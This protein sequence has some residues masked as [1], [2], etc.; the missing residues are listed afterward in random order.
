MEIQDQGYLENTSEKLA[1]VRAYE[2]MYVYVY[3]CARVK[4]FVV[5]LYWNGGDSKPQDVLV[6]RSRARLRPHFLSFYLFLERI[7]YGSTL[8]WE[9]VYT[10]S[11]S[12]MYMQVRGKAKV[13]V[14]WS[15]TNEHW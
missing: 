6:D 7:T 15:N 4:A 8:R 1:F 12:C 3:M 11:R 14:P 13:N 5:A 10:L 2:Y 9:N